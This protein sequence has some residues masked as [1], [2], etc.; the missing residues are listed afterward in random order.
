MPRFSVTLDDAQN[1]W[2]ERRAEELNGS[3][4]QVISV[5]VDAAR[6]GKLDPPHP[7]SAPDDAVDRDV[8]EEVEALERRV[9][10]LEASLEASSNP[11]PNAGEGEHA[12]PGRRGDQSP[13]SEEP[14][15]PGNED[16]S[17][18]GDRCGTS[19]PSEGDE[20]E[21]AAVEELVARETDGTAS[22]AEVLACWELLKNRGTASP[23]AF[24]QQCGPAD[25]GSEAEL[26]AWWEE[27]VEPVLSALPGVDPPEDNARFYRYP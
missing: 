6:A 9:A 18:A 13:A 20:P 7:L 12:A 4:T 14:P 26:A 16:A 8:R 22:P 2:V 10:E 11:E 19:L 23:R 15:D 5:L 17:G 1:G 21:A 27:G 25:A 3:K 24:K